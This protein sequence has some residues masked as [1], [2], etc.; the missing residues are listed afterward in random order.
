MLE[1]FF[2]NDSINIAMLLFGKDLIFLVLWNVLILKKRNYST[3]ENKVSTNHAL[4]L[5]F[6]AFLFISWQIERGVN[7]VP[8]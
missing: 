7:D 8:T 1:L 6:C 3:K 5:F 2:R 4:N